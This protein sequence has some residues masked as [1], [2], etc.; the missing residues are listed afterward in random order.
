MPQ[1]TVDDIRKRLGY[2]NDILEKDI[3]CD[4]CIHFEH[5]YDYY[6]LDIADADGTITRT[7]KTRMTKRQV[8]DALHFMEEILGLVPS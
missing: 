7:I 1:V 3:R 4:G 5:R 2:I 6:A 8:Y